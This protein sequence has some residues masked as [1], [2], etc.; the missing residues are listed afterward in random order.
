MTRSKEAARWLVLAFQFPKNAGSARMKI[1]RR[2]QAIGAISVRSS[3][4][5]LPK[6]EETK[7]DFAWLLRDL[8]GYEA[9]GVLFEAECVGGLSDDELIQAFNRQRNDEYKKL[10]SDIDEV[11]DTDLV[12]EDLGDLRKR[13]NRLRKQVA[14]VEKVDFF[15]ATGRA[16]VESKILKIEKGIDSAGASPPVTGSEE[17]QPHFSELLGRK[18]VTRKGVGV[19]R[20]ATA[21]LV[22]RWIDSEASFEFVDE[23]TYVWRSPDIRFDM[24]EGE[25]THRQDMCTFEVLVQQYFPDDRG[26]KIIGEIVHDL[27]LK[28]ER[29]G[30]PETQ[31]VA[32]LL[33]GIRR[34]SDDDWVRI[35]QGERLFD[36]LYEAL[37]S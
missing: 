34:E 25:F 36:S 21:W 9:E 31:G 3:V 15:A 28:D 11:L 17:P 23:A 4:Y 12:S 8:E 29:F 10:E 2:I 5:V 24:Y 14:D 30:R 13:V 26:L 20:I 19:D 35:R 22:R 32:A 33:T 1:W 18:W 6:S 27:D 7:E 16:A 37:K